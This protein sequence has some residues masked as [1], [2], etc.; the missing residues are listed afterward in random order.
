MDWRLRVPSALYRVARDKAGSD[1]ELAAI[2]V[3]WL[4]QWATDAP[5]RAPGPPRRQEPED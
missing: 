3:R 4:E 1:H 2:V 5:R